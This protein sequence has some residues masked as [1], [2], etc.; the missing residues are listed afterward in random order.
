MSSMLTLIASA[1]GVVGGLGG[2]AVALWYVTKPAR[3]RRQ[4]Q[5]RAAAAMRWTAYPE[6]DPRRVALAPQR[7]PARNGFGS[8]S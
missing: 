1:V 5:R 3:R 6:G 2:N 4:M 7:E 8:A